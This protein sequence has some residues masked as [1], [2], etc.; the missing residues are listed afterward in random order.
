[1]NKELESKSKSKDPLA[2]EFMSD[3]SKYKVPTR[4]EQVK[5]LN[6]IHARRMDVEDL[7]KTGSDKDLIDKKTAEMLDARNELVTRNMRFVVSIAKNFRKRGFPLVDLIS[8]GASG[9]IIAADK[10]NPKVHKKTKF[11]TYAGFWVKREITRAIYDK[12]RAIRLPVYMNDKITQW[13][14]I[15]NKIS[16]ARVRSPDAGEI[17][18]EISRED[19]KEYRKSTQE[20][21]EKALNV[22]AYNL[23]NEEDFNMNLIPDPKQG[24]SSEEYEE[25]F[26]ALGA[27]LDEKEKTIISYRFGLGGNP[28]MT[29]EEIGGIIGLTRERVRQI[30]LEALDKTRAVM[31]QKRKLAKLKLMH[32]KRTQK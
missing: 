12:G 25:M 29:L 19:N 21:I 1:M 8:Y 28:E 7:K 23:P 9:L 22:S 32:K 27:A 20:C 24:D 18:E 6:T 31:S 15:A 3:I 13:R 2:A 10:F 4:S 16:A 14:K 17:M 5:L 11:T 30:I 26:E